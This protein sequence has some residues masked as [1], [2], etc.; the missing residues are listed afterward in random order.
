MFREVPV[1]PVVVPVAAAALLILLWRLRRR[2]RLSAPRAAVALVLCVYAAGVV[3]NTVFPIFL[4]MPAR[5]ASWHASLHVV[6]LA[7]Y[8]VADAVMNILVFAPLGMLLPLLVVRTS[9]WRVLAMAAGVSLSIEMAQY[10]TA[11]SLGGGHIA[12][13]NDFTFNVLG[14]LL[15]FSLLAAVSRVPGA[16]VVIDRFRWR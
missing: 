4:N 2:E 7:N 5:S 6:P 15:G 14:G 9:W 11:R 1:L 3:A 13:V 10:V 8:E 16:T 12:D